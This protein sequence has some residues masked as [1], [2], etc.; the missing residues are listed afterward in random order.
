MA[1]LFYVK[2]PGTAWVGGARMLQKNLQDRV[3]FDVWKKLFFSVVFGMKCKKN[4]VYAGFPTRY[5][6][7]SYILLG[8]LKR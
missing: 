7:I 3:D 5:L 8:R 2:K 6:S 1:G 4:I